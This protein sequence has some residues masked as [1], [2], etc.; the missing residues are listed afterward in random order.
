MNM[1]SVDTSVV[2]I[3]ILASTLNYCV[4]LEK[5]LDVSESD[6]GPRETSTVVTVLT[7]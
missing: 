6:S 2:K 4:T 5:R 7:A 3:Q 1:K